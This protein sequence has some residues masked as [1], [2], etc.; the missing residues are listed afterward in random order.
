MA[1]YI[2]KTTMKAYTDLSQSKK[3]AE[4]L[5]LESADM[6]YRTDGSVK[7]MWEHLKNIPVT[8]PCWSLTA[9]L[10][11]LPYK[12]KLSHDV[13]DANNNPAYKNECYKLSINRCGLFGDKW[14]VQYYGKHQRQLG[15][16]YKEL[17]IDLFLT[18]NYDNLVDA[19]YEMIISLN[20]LKML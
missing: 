4:F 20:E 7:L 9:L 17:Y 5:P 18:E 8:T 10:S 16:R 2:D 6:F 19:C 11:I 3:L 13:I 1:Q 15:K 12:I 14:N